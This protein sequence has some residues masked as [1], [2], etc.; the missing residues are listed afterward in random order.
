MT[1]RGIT[2]LFDIQICMCC[3]LHYGKRTKELSMAG[4]VWVQGFKLHIS[5]KRHNRPENRTAGENRNEILREWNQDN[6]RKHRRWQ[7]WKNK[8][9]VCQMRSLTFL[10]PLGTAE[11]EFVE[12]LTSLCW[13]LVFLLHKVIVNKFFPQN[14]IVRIQ[15]D[16]KEP[17]MVVVV[18]H[19]LSHSSR[20]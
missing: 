10:S 14:T 15:R 18:Q 5:L 6:F 1:V 13:D 19:T 17:L 4:R 9:R 8:A 7:V 20:W 2:L 3:L 12:Q 16:Q 11:G